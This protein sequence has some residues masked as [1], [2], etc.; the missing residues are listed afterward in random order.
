MPRSSEIER[1]LSKHG[2]EV[3]SR[4][5]ADNDI[6]MELLPYLTDADLKELGVSV[7]HKVVFRKAT[8][9][10]PK[11]A[12]GPPALPNADSEVEPSQF[13]G[14]RKLISVLFCDIVESTRL[15]TLLDAEELDNVLQ[16]FFSRC[17]SI[18]EGFGGFLAAKQGD[19]AM[20]WFGWPQA[21][22]DDPLR[23]VHAGLT[24]T[25]ELPAIEMTFASD[26]RMNVRI[27]IATGHVVI[28]G[29][30][31]SEIP[32]IVGETPNRA[33]RMKQ[34][35]PVASVVIDSATRRLV[36]ANF[37]LVEL[38]A[39]SLKG[40]SGSAQI[41]QVV[42][43]R[44]GVTR[45]EGSHSGEVVRRLVGRQGDMAMLESRWELV[46]HGEGQVVLLTG[47][48]GIGKSRLAAAFAERAAEQACH[49]ELYQ[50]SQ[51][52]QNTALHS[53]ISRITRDA[54][55][56]FTD[57]PEEK[58]EKLHRSMHPELAMNEHVVG[59]FASL[60][61]IPAQEGFLPPMRPEDWRSA[62]LEAILQRI[63]HSAEQKPVLLI[64]EDVHWI[65]PTSL[66]L[67]DA[68]VGRSANMRILVLMT[69]RGEELIGRWSEANNFTHLQLNRLTPSQSREFCEEVVGSEALKKLPLENIVESAQGLPLFLEELTKHAGENLAEAAVERNT[70]QVTQ[71]PH[72]TIPDHLFSFLSERLDRLDAQTGAKRVAQTAAVFGQECS[73]SLLGKAPS[74]RTID[75]SAAVDHLVNAGLAAKS[76][77]AVPG[78]LS[79]R[80]AIFRD[81]AYA[82]LLRSTRRALHGEIATLLMDS[83][84]A[85]GEPNIVAYHLTEAHR[86]KEAIA[87][88]T[89]AGL[90]SSE[91]S[92][93]AEAF[94]HFSKALELIGQLPD[95]PAMHELELPLRVGFGGVASAIEGYSAQDIE[96]NYTRML[97][98]ANAL[99][100]PRERFRAHLGLGAFYEVGGDIE[101]SQL[102]CEECLRSAELSGDRDELLHAHR[103]MGELSFFKADFESSCRHLEA[104]LSLYDPKDHLR[105]I[106]ELGDDPAV[107]SHVYKALSLW[108]L[109][110]PDQAKE[111]SRLGLQ[112]ADQHRHAFSSAQADFYASWLYAFARDPNLARRFAEKSIDRSTAEHFALVLGCSRVLKGWAMVRMNEQKAGHEEILQ[113]MTLIRGPNA[114]ICESSMLTFL[115]DYH[116]LTGET[117]QGLS[118]VEESRAVATERFAD[119][120]RLRLQ[121]E[122]LAA[123]DPTAAE[124][125]LR[126]A[127]ATAN[128]QKS[129]SMALRSA[130]S[131]YRLL[132]KH[133][134]GHEAERLLKQVYDQF[135]EGFDTADLAEAGM[136][137]KA[138]SHS[139]ANA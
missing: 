104:A 82:S 126:D 60:L 89:K 116:L 15:S 7:G 46:R 106:E 30:S 23:A 55:I 118:V 91:Q 101:K 16:A 31:G 119:T 9:S 124:R 49:V 38:G 70:R 73:I 44:E 6:R 67:I 107:L 5:F 72:T 27:G 112:L 75:V 81:V 95:E 4:A 117:E 52:H 131:L 50:C 71:A 114:D 79:F 18:V 57:E 51:L 39:R 14:E 90:R 88:W 100:R 86:P 3:Y 1:W 87:H 63:S 115:A 56:K 123:R 35:C 99:N 29:I 136:I 137:L 139:K 103:L 25:R 41:C 78:A 53:V 109:G 43:P 113:G 68:I 26:W 121:G 8:E 34:A 135:T 62:V 120:D 19:G 28:T 128:R 59:L 69:S 102:H 85:E 74:L 48:A 61:S 11:R 2:L 98:L 66:E 45:F 132:D 80:H 10:L 64:I 13:A 37:E 24:M 58:L 12:D 108:F 92:A 129:L 65:D 54:D 111:S 20:C 94:S 33:E 133:G 110:F 134:R 76:T 42:G 32:Q 130:L 47:Q 22:E 84:I 138:R 21:H 105:L 17:A 122:L 83:G 125:I 96:K 36:G 40:F 97:E 77:G 93:T 127:L